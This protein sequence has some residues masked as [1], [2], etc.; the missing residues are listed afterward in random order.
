MEPAKGIRDLVVP[1]SQYPHMPY[2]AALKEAVVLLK[3]A[4]ETGRHTILVFDEGYRL[5]GMLQRKHVLKG[6]DAPGGKGTARQ[7]QEFMSETSVR[8]DAEESIATASRVMAGN[9]ACLLPVMEGG[10]LIGVLRMD[11]LYEELAEAGLRAP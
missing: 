1:I 4:Y 2:W 7:I 8:I 3:A 9:D 10:K 5:V 6:I 11:D